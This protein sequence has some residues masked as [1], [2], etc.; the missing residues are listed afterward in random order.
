MNLLKDEECLTEDAFELLL[1]L[2]S[3]ILQAVCAR[4][5]HLQRVFVISLSVAH[6][7]RESSAVRN[8]TISNTF[9][10]TNKKNRGVR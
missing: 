7:E 6:I 9:D 4:S 10:S 1:T 3:I 5:Q 2:E 8:R